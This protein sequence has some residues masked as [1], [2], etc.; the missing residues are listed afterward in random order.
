MKKMCFFALFLFLALTLFACKEESVIPELTLKVNEVSLNVGDKYEI[1]ATI[2]NVEAGITVRVVQGNEYV[3]VEG[4]ILTA[5]KEG[6]AKIE[7]SVTGYS[8]VKA[9]LTVKV[10]SKEIAPELEVTTKQVLLNSGNQTCEVEAVVKNS[11]AKILYEI[12]DGEELISLEGNIISLKGNLSGT[13]VVRVS[14]EGYLN[15]YVDVNVEVSFESDVAAPKLSIE[16]G[17][18]TD[19]TLNWGKEV[20]DEFLMKGVLAI[21]DVDG[22]ITDS[23]VISHN[24]NNK[25]YGSYN[26]T[27]ESTDS[28][29]NKATIGRVVNVIWDYAVEFI[30]HQGSFYGVPNTEE[31]FIYAAEKLQYQALET[32]VK[33]TKD[34]VF[35]CSH[36]DTF[37]GVTI[38][39]VTW[40]EL[41]DVEVTTTRKAG[42][43]SQYGELK[44]NGVYTSKICSLERYLEICKQYNIKAVV[45]LKDSKGI[46]NSDQTRMP[47]LMEL[48]RATDMLNQTIFL[49]SAYNCLIWVKQNGYDYIPCQ[50]LVGSCESETYYQRCVTYGLDISVNTTYGDY[51]NGPEWIARYHEAGLKVSTYTYTQYVDYKD[52]QKWIDLGVDFVTCDWHSMDK[53]NLPDNS[54][55]VY[56][57][58]KF[59]D[60]NDNLLKEAKVKHGQTAVSPKVPEIEGYAFTT[61]SEDISNV[62][63][64][65]EVKAEYELVNYEIKYN[66]NLYIATK[67]SWETKEDFVND[68]YN[69]L[70]EWIVANQ[71]NLPCVTYNEGVYTIK[72]NSTEYGFATF[73]SAKDIKG[74]NVYNFERTFATLIYKPINGTNS[75]DY[76]PEVD[77][78]YFLNTEPYRSKYI[79]CNKYFLNVMKNAYQAY[80]YTYN[81]ASNNRVQIFFRFHQWCNGNV[82]PAFNE[83]PD[84]YIVKYLV[85]VEVTLPTEHLT[86]T[87]EDE[88]VL[89]EPVA[90]IGFLGWFTEQDGTGEQITEIKKGS[91]GNITLYAKWEEIELPE[92]YSNITYELDGGKNN[93]AN[94]DTYLEGVATMLFPAYKEG[95]KFLGWSK[96]KD[97]NSYIASISELSS[98][99]ITL[100]ANYEYE[101]Y[102]IKYD[103]Q[104]GSWGNNVEFTGSPTTS[105]TTNGKDDFW[106]EANGYKTKIY[107]D[108]VATHPKAVWSHRVGIAFNNVLNM[109]V[110]VSVAESGES[111][112]DSIA[113]YVIT[114]SGSYEGYSSTS[115][116]R[117]NVKVGQGIK[118]TGDLDSGNAT[119]EFYAED[120]ISGGTVENYVVEYTIATL[121]QQLPTPKLE[122]KV[123]KGWSLNADLS[124]EVLT[125][126]PLGIIGNIVLY[127]VYE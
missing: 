98:G 7:V 88:F 115:G 121:P 25:K 78:N 81:Q 44:G 72:V 8:D 35:V 39:N 74:V 94:L 101:V 5:L 126:L 111:F 60:Q 21:D 36:D 89:P 71:D 75:D 87:I 56:H 80:S 91:T 27:Y 107:L 103:L 11:L 85:G 102:I 90:S 43:P 45:E 49:A 64:D 73:S 28:A 112:D 52:V 30:G 13:A 120:D 54:E 55:V 95:Y 116:Y 34:G 47:A 14:L 26:V 18:T 19:L 59:Y 125:E 10:S 68:F 100:Y 109:Y 62:T 105:I 6:T 4:N 122:G 76:V 108:N 84:K 97:G 113:E 117:S 104:N 65:L 67:S 114:I 92:V 96:E 29:G 37:G 83:Y 46:T 63:S 23:V 42:Y 93:E 66:S 17:E 16:C 1:E 15:I 119:L 77:N 9:D 82:I 40:E 99:D 123:F 70:F 12:I 124:G 32:D 2:K 48:I 31:A 58:V 57:T 118:V 41:K 106:S 38:A 24:I 3:S 79:E 61:W 86:Y 110:V 22:N 127:A 50:F 53:L 33:Q 69:D 20:T 51:S